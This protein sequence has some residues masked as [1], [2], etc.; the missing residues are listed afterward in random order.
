MKKI[1]GICEII[2]RDN[3]FYRYM[4]YIRVQRRR[5]WRK[6]WSYGFQVFLDRDWEIIFKTVIFGNNEFLD[7]LIE[8]ILV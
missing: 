2:L 8:S 3:I 4:I 6:D 1:V 7:F 5:N